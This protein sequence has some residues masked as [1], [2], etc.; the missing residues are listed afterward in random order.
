MKLITSSTQYVRRLITQPV[1]ELNRAQRFLRFAMELARHCT[2]QLR[3]DRAGTMAAALTYHTLFSLLPTI[4]LVLVALN[5]FVGPDERAKFKESAVNYVVDAMKSQASEDEKVAPPKSDDGDAKAEAPI[6]GSDSDALALSDKQIEFEEVRQQ[7]NQQFQS[8]LDSLEQISFGSIGLVGVLVF[9][10]GATGLLATVERSFNVVYGVNSAR[11]W[12]YRLPLYYTTITLGPI[13]LLAGQWMQATFLGFLESGN[14]TNWSV[15][16]AVVAAPLVTTW[17]VI[18]LMY[19]LLPKT[20]VAKRAAAIGSLVAAVMLVGSRELF[21]LYVGQAA[22]TT[23]YGALALLPLFLLLLWV[24]WV[25]VLFGLELTY[26]LQAMKGRKFD[27]IESKTQAQTGNPQWL[28]P[29]MAQ[30]GKS[31]SS[32][33][34]IGRDELADRLH[35]PV[36]AVTDLGSRLE[37]AGLIYQVERKGSEEKGLALAKPAE[38]ISIAS[39]IELGQAMSSRDTGTNSAGWAYVEKL[40]DAQIKAAADT[41]LASLLNGA[42]QFKPGE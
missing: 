40:N 24:M 7:L 18:F 32:G 25:I 41:T 4:V 35:L 19:A 30:I 31:F 28:I 42:G 2:R 38:A 27:A 9:I 13:V 8:T 33:E 5:A 39:L 1:G 29:I 6:D 20:S 21:R 23:L 15:R 3:K 17:L 10:Y 36:V 14:L 12:Y 11:P 37:E 22:V 26:T 34:P 16:P